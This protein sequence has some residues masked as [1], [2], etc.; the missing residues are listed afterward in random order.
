MISALDSQT[1]L[2]LDSNSFNTFLDLFIFT[3]VFVDFD[4]IMS[5]VVYTI[6]NTD[7]KDYKFNY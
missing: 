5:S 4:T 1:G 3:N 2:S 7:G 6:I